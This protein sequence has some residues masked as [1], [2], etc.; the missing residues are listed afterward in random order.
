MGD[1][2]GLFQLDKR[3]CLIKENLAYF[4]DDIEN[5]TGDDWN[6]KPYECNAG[7]PYEEFD[8]LVVYFD[9]GYISRRPGTSF[10]A[11]GYISLEEI[12]QS[13]GSF[14]VYYKDGDSISYGDTLKKFVES[15]RK[16]EGNAYFLVEV[17]IPED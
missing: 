15:L 12:K 10:D 13:H 9:E 17:E 2:H 6:D 5:V 11:G 14:I 1:V 7:D 8:P 16:H 3:L 4:V